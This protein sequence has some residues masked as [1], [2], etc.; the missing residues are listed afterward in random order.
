MFRIYITLSVGGVLSVERSVGGTTVA[1]QLN[2]GNAL[3]ANCAYIFDI[4]VD[5]GETINFQ[6]SVAA[7]ILK[8]SVREIDASS[9]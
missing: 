2:S 6:T 9:S 1:E 5:S 7:T 8:F 3:T 4:V